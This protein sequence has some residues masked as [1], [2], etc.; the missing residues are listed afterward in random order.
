VGLVVAA[1]AAPRLVVAAGAAVGLVVAAGAAL[2]SPTVVVAARVPVTAYSP[3]AVREVA[4]TSARSPERPRGR[5]H[6]NVRRR[7]GVG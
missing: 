7:P 4:R 1:G 3:G 5:L 6:G 2:A